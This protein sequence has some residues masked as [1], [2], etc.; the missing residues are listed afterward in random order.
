MV[1]FKWCVE[2]ADPIRARGP[3]AH[4]TDRAVT[5]ETEATEMTTTGTADIRE[6]AVMAAGKR[7]RTRIN[8]AAMFF[9]LINSLTTMT[10]LL[11]C[12]NTLLLLL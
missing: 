5:V 8:W 11:L 9:L 6:M 10:I 1:H 4:A 12:M 7:P 2:T 3:E